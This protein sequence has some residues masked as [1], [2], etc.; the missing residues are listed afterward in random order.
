MNTKH[1]THWNFDSQQF[2]ANASTSVPS[3]HTLMVLVVLQTRSD[4]GHVQAARRASR[5]VLL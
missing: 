5:L 1:N 4:E 2:P 3:Y